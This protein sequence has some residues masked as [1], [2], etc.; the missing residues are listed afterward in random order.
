VSSLIE[1]ILPVFLIIGIG[2]IAAKLK[3]LPSTAVD[4]VMLFTQ[5]FAI[6]CLLFNAMANIE[7]SNYFNFLLIMS[8]FTPSLIGFFLGILI[9]RYLLKYSLEKS[10]V[11][12]FCCLYSNS[13]M[14][15]LPIME[16]AYGTNSLG[17]NY[18]IIALNTPFCYVTGIIFME[19]VKGRGNGFTSTVGKAV[20]GIFNNILVLSILLGVLV[21]VLEVII[22]TTIDNAVNIIIKAAIPTAIFGLGGV[23]ARYKVNGDI[24]PVLVIAFIALLM[25]PSLGFYLGEYNQ[26]DKDSIRAVVLT[27]AMAPGLNAYIFANM[28]NTGTKIAAT[29]VLFSTALSVFT[30]WYWLGALP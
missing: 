27:A 15:G 3:W 23:L 26:L 24:L 29:S 30:L 8:Y 20:K 17:P 1:V 11:I 18:A 10:V 14:L 22:P 25:K 19:F 7:I 16:Q 28:Y 6:P 4:G 2:F 13:L 21:N 9:S 5:R 12:G